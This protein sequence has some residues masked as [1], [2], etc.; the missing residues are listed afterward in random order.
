MANTKMIMSQM[1]RMKGMMAQMQGMMGKTMDD[2]QGMED[3][4]TAAPG[5]WP[6]VW[7]DTKKS[8]KAAP[9]TPSKAGGTHAMPGGKTMTKEQMK[10]VFRKGK[11]PSKATKKT[12]TETW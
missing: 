4:K 12:K 7:P 5:E 8:K 3:T 11:G 9:K 10:A 1:G 2:M 6:N